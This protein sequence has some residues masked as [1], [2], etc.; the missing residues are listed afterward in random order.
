MQ[1]LFTKASFSLL[2]RCGWAPAVV[3]VAHHFIRSATWRQQVDF[4]MHFSG[5][6][7]MGYLMLHALRHYEPWLGRVTLLGR[8]IFSFSLALTIGVMWEFLE[9]A[10]DA[11]LGTHIQLSIWET[12]RD[13]IADCLGA[14]FA[15]L[16]SWVFQKQSF[17]QEG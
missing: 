4:C 11:L 17:R 15:L 12:L 16:L 9:M 8:W 6:M 13:L 2:R 5:G 10:S 3:L 7:A 14:L 1:P